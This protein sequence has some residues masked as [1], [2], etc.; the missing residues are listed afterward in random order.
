[1]KLEKNQFKKNMK[2]FESNR[3]NLTILWPEIWDQ[4]N[5]TEKKRLK[6]PQNSRSNNLILK[7]EVKNIN[8][9]KERKKTQS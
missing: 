8:L 5:P 2:K 1:M 6:N 4:D 3:V 9:I 7:G